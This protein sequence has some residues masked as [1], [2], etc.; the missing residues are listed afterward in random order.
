MKI[1]V[2]DSYGLQQKIGAIAGAVLKPGGFYLSRIIGGFQ[3][4]QSGLKF[5]GPKAI[6]DSVTHDVT[7][8]VDLPAPIQLPTHRYAEF[9]SLPDSDRRKVNREKV[10]S[11]NEPDLVLCSFDA[12]TH[13]DFLGGL[14]LALRTETIQEVSQEE[15][16]RIFPETWAARKSEI[17]HGVPAKAGSSSAALFDVLMNSRKVHLHQEA[18]ESDDSI[19]A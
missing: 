1:D 12:Y 7:E 8:L 17:I 9:S 4:V 10:R 14:L 6:V 16:E 11:L 5:P 3:D 13:D 15:M 2:D 19:K 18:Q